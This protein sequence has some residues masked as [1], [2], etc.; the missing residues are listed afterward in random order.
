MVSR[1]LLSLAFDICEEEGDAEGLR[2]LRRAMVCYFLASKPE[3]LDS[4]YASFTMIDLVVELVQSP[5]TRKRM[6]YY[7]TINPTGTAGGELFRDKYVEQ[8]VRAVKMHLRGTHGCVDDIKLEKEVGCLSL[9]TEITQH[10]RRSVL[11]GKTGKEHSQDMIGES[12]REVIEDNV[13]LADP[14]NKS[15]DTRYT[16][17]DVPSSSPYE[18]LTSDMVIKFL[19]RKKREYMLKYT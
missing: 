19:Q 16:F 7:V 10:N 2:A 9:I 3:R 15:R 6:D 1:L 14:F 12:T 4:K 8:C 5:R 11:R 13:A 18:G 17:L